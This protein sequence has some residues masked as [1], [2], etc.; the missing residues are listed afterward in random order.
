MAV[1]NTLAC[2]NSVTITAVKRFKVEAI[3]NNK[4]ILKALRLGMDVLP[5]ELL[6]LLQLHFCM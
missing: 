2:Y 1:A 4:A 6:G 3:G 5:R